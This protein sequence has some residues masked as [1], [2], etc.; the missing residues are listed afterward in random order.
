MFIKPFTKIQ[1]PAITTSVAV[2]PVY[3]ALLSLAL[4][5]ADL[6]TVKVEPWITQT[7][8]HLTPQ[9]QHNNRLV[10]EGLG[11]V[12]LPDT[13]YADFPT[14]LAALE[15]QTP[16]VLRDRLLQHLALA[17]PQDAATPVDQPGFIQQLKANYPHNH[18]DETVVA[19]CT[20]CSQNRSPCIV[21]SPTTCAPCGRIT[22]RQNGNGLH[23]TCRA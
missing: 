16:T 9:Q 11:Q 8:V 20:N 17:K 22:W 15:A 1:L 6:T 18:L 12:L 14:Y 3:N 10:F 2:E 13:A 19:E 4:L 7:A 21:L 23:A 5:T